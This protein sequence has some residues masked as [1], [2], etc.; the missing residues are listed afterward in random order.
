MYQPIDAFNRKPDEDIAGLDAL[1]TV[2]SSHNYLCISVLPTDK[3]ITLVQ[4]S[5][6][7]FIF[8]QLAARN[9]PSAP[10]IIHG[11]RGF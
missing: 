8:T 7:I 2:A 1:D 6:S 10:V 5:T 4:L 11:T 9:L 3:V